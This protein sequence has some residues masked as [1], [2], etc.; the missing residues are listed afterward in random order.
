MVDQIQS[1]IDSYIAWLRDK[2]SLR[3]VGEWVEITTPFLDRHNDYIQIYA[4]KENGAFVL[5]DDAYT[6]DDLR[7]SGCELRSPK[8]QSLLQVTLNGFGV[9]MDGDALVTRATP[10][11]FGSRKHNLVQAILAVNDLFYLAPASV[12]SL[13]WEDVAEWLRLADVRFVERVKFTGKSG[14]DH[15]FDFVIPPSREAP[16]RIVQAINRPNRDTAQKA[17]FSWFDTREVRTEASR[18][19]AI[20][21]D[22]DHEPP[23]DVI[24]ALTRYDVRP[25][26][27]SERE[28]VRAELAA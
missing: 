3:E 22:S 8:R 19:Y 13:F 9:Q 24:A 14:F 25:I 26:R 4:R 27:W 5:T 18:A 12:H 21:N 11:D 20:L 23:A 1:L 10:R 28:S 7:R 17:A 15:M 6:I 2:T 16:E